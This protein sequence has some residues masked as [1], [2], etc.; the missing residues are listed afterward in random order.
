MCDAGGCLTISFSGHN[1]L[2]K[3]IKFASYTPDFTA[4]PG[5]FINLLLAK[6]TSS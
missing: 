2:K 4:S 1:K 3:G 6:T 5:Q